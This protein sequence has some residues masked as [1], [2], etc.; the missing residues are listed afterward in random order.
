MELILGE[1][2]RGRSASIWNSGAIAAEC[3]L[4]WWTPPALCWSMGF[5]YKAF[6]Y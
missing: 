5:I 2:E 3:L 4:S 6:L 1:M